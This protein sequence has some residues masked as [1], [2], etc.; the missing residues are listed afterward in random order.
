MTDIEIR[1]L[2]ALEIGAAIKEG[3]I[4]SYEATKA[5]LDAIDAKDGENTITG[6]SKNDKITAGMDD[7]SVIAARG[8]R[9]HWLRHLRFRTVPI[10]AHVDECLF[11]LGGAQ[12]LTGWLGFPCDGYGYTDTGPDMAIPAASLLYALSD[13]GVQQLPAD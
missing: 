13:H 2:G 5:F 10:A 8:V 3:K 4:T 1:K 12:L 7:D 11:A 6:S 9:L